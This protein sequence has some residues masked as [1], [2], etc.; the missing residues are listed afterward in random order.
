KSY[1]LGLLALRHAE[2]YGERAKILYL[3]RT[4]AGVRDF[5]GVTR[6]LFGMVYGTAARFNAAEGIWRLLNGAYMEL[7]QIDDHASYQRF[8]GRSFSLLLIDEAGQYPSLELL[9]LLR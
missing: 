1:G 2:T 5:E 6:E 7:S 4:F 9:D 8:Q 3:R